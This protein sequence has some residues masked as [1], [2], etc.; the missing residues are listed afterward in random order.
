MVDVIYA[1][2]FYIFTLYFANVFRIFKNN[3]CKNYHAHD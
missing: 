2:S 3:L 1:R